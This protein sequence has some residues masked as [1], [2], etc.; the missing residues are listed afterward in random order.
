MLLAEA[1]QWPE[2]A[3]AYFGKGDEFHLAFNFPVMPRLFMALRMEDRF[4]I[5]DILTQTPSIPDSCQWALFLRNHDELTLEMVTD[6]ERDYMYR[7]YAADPTARINL[8][9]R[10]R[11]APLLGNDRKKI[12]LMNSLLFSLPGTPVIYYG[13][14]IGMG[15]NFYLGDRNGVRTPMQWSPERNAGFSRANPQRLFLPPIIDP[16]YHYEAVNTENQIN[17]P[18][19]LLWWMKRLIALRKRYRAFGRG[20]INFLQPENRKVLAYFRQYRDETILV[21]ANLSHLAQQTKLDLSEFTG[22]RPVDLFGRVEFAPV[23]GPD[24]YFTLSPYAFFWF[25]LEPQPVEPSP[26]TAL[27]AETAREIPLLRETEEALF[28]KKENWFVMEAILLDYIKGQR[29]FRGKARDARAAEIQ[30]IVPM[31]FDNATSHVI[32]VEV[33]YQEGEAEIYAIPLTTAP[34]EREEEI[35]EKYPSA[36]VAYLKTRGKNNKDFLYDAMVNNDFTLFLL[37]AI[38]RRRTFKST[39]GDII[40]SPTSFLTRAM[41]SAIKTLKPSTL[42]TEQSN[43]SIAFGDKLIL[44]LFR[45]LEDGINPDL[46]IGQFLTEKTP[47][48]NIARAAGSLEYQ[49][50]RNQPVSLAILQSFVPNESDA[51]QYTLDSL[52]RYFET[53]LAHPTV[54]TPPV[55]HKPLLSLPRELP[56]LAQDTIGM[57]IASSQLLG[58]RTAELHVA[59][60]SEP[61]DIDFSPVPYTLMY[62]ISL[63]QSLRGSAM[64]TLQLLQENLTRL[65]EESQKDARAV[66]DMENTII[67]RYN[68]IRREKIVA[69]RI[70][71]HGDYHLGQ[72]LYTGKDF[73]IT[74]FEGEPAR[75]LSERR[76]K[77]SPLRDVAGMIRSFSYAAYPALA[78]LVTLHQKNG[79]TPSTVGQWAQYWYVWVSVVFLNTY[80]DVTRHTGLVP[81]DPVQLKI[82]L[83]AFLL[84]KALYEVS[85]ELNNRP[86]WVRVPLQGIIQMLE[87][88][89]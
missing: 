38:Q 79:D 2:D 28:G 87:A 17:N 37:N 86:D 66:L 71:C 50:G 40:A 23:N 32:L 39:A 48:S 72:V 19:S 5:I 12:E 42:K 56:S 7:V 27:P 58:Q 62:Q 31:H 44:K 53:V 57:Y 11:L 13:D 67:D 89:G 84:E 4:P 80:L 30:D 61:A 29:W 49:S 69:S 9:I 54:Q 76:I 24:Y 78:K 15:D 6:E 41:A 35:R 34:V 74:D 22:Y 51:W 64:R 85:Y 20:S 68:L 65:P 70:R 88:E 16:E 47:F 10:R 75:S 46:E 3:A 45:K 81:E 1:N 8:G 21:V 55:P 73:V 33:E 63:Y 18:D 77:R 25:S 52:E 60:A 14:E 36:I 26:L 82:L 59:L 83:D 43:T